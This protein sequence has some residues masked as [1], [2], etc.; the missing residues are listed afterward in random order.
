MYVRRS[1]IEINFTRSVAKGRGYYLNTHISMS[2][3]ARGRLLVSR[4]LSGVAYF[5]GM[6][7]QEEPR[8]CSTLH[9]VFAYD[10]RGSPLAS[11]KCHPTS[12]CYRI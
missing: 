11:L 3:K 9:A 8:I 4:W 7:E 1:E 2:G 6:R 12:F 10:K 5:E